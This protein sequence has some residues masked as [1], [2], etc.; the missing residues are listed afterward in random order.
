VDE[1]LYSQL[2]SIPLLRSGFERTHANN[3]MAGADGV[4]IRMFELRLEQ[5]LLTLH[6]ELLNRSYC[7][8][9]L[10]RIDIPKSDGTTRM[11]DMDEIWPD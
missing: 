6:T 3:G 9:P 10:F 8:Q 4:S 1:T 7:P 5:E 2:I 11:L